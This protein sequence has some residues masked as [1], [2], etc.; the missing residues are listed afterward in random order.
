MICLA[1]EVGLIGQNTGVRSDL[2]G[3]ADGGDERRRAFMLTGAVQGG[4]A[5]AAAGG[6]V[7]ML[8]TE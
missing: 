1:S 2:Y 7:F 6:L 8:L 5:G 4:L 3:I